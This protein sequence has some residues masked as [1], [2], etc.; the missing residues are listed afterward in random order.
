MSHKEVQRQ[1]D[2]VGDRTKKADALTDAEG[3]RAGIRQVAEEA[4]VSVASVS[5]TLNKPETVS[6]GM[7]RRVQAA[8]ERLGYV[9]NSAARAL[10]LQRTHAIGAI[11]PSLDYSIFARFIEA[12]QNRAGKSG[13]SVMLSTC[14]FAPDYQ[15]RELEQA[16]AL[17]GHGIDA[18]IVSGEHHRA[19]LYRLLEARAIPYAHTSVYNSDSPHPCVGY[20]NKGAAMQVVAHLLSLG[21]ENFGAL[22]GARVSND[23]M[24]LRIEGARTAL[25]ER[26]LALP[27]S[28]IVERPFSIVQ[29]RAGFRELI[30]RE[31]A[32]TALICGNDVLAFGVLLEAQAM[33]V[34]V[35]GSLS[36][37]GFDN[38]EWAAEIEPPLTTVQVP[39]FDMGVATADYLIG[40]LTGV[41]VPRHTKI[42]TNLILRGTT[43]PA[44]SR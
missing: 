24:T 22:I 38:L 28:R 8:I 43:G 12:L 16:R 20:D 34:E 7:Q 18:L 36:V 39:T 44:P 9:P 2:M 13:Y 19:D 31:P 11:V 23:R 42:E 4:G 3:L 29:A 30:R 5:R 21:H 15:D 26:G 40:E 10:S 17:I 37:V 1:V 27:E 6:E 41:P 14:G 35:P 32:I 33:G 25:E